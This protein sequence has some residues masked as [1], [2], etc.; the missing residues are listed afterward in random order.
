MIIMESDPTLERCEDPERVVSVAHTSKEQTVVVIT[1]SVC[2]K[3]VGCLTRK[4]I[5]RSS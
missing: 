4:V 3:C 5:F 2:G 1:L